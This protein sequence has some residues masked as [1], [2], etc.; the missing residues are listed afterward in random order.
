LASQQKENNSDVAQEQTYTIREST[1]EES[2][3]ESEVGLELGVTTEVKC[4]VPMLAEGKIE[5]SAT[6]HSNLKWGTANR[7]TKEWQAE[8]KLS[9]PPHSKGR[10]T[11]TI[12]KSVMVVPFTST[13]KSKSTGNTMVT[14]GV[15]KGVACADFK[16]TDS[17]Y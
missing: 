11:A 16:T 6:A 1:E 4:G 17:V 2:T 14:T 3:F 7:T 9:V 15:Y 12:L 8:I 10:V 13:W 5:I